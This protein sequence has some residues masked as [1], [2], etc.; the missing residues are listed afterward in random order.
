MKIA[1]CSSGN[2]LEATADPRFGRCAYFLVVDT[3][4]FDFSALQNPGTS[5]SQG[6]GI[7]AA[8]EEWE[9]GR[10]HWSGTGGFRRGGRSGPARV[11]GHDL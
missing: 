10:R 9:D 3:D 1:V 4:T 7:Q 11:S 2:T 8:Q 5:V 6:A